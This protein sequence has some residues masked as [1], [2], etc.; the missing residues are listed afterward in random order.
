MRTAAR[1]IKQLVTKNKTIELK[2]GQQFAETPKTYEIWGTQKGKI[3]IQRIVI[4][5]KSSVQ[6]VIE[7]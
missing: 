5:R 3:L 6:W 7:K 4:I 2:E 1:N